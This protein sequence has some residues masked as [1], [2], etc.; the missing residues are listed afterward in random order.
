MLLRCLSLAANCFLRKP[1]CC[2]LLKILNL[3][4]P[5]SEYKVQVITSTNKQFLKKFFKEFFGGL[6][7]NTVE[8]G[9]VVQC[10]IPWEGVEN[11]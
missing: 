9:V 1:S 5:Q 11:P 10:F 8:L 6:V 7:V 4:R 3:D 2:F